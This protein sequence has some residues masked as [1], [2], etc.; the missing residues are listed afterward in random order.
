MMSLREYTRK[1]HFQ[2]TPEPVGKKVAKEGRS[3]VVQKH[4]AT[5][6]HYDFRLELEGVLKSWAVPK[7]PSLDPSVKR[8]A[9][10][11]EDHPVDYGNFEGTIP[12][13]EYGGGTVML[14]DRGYWEPVGDARE[15]Y[16]NGRLKFKLHGEKLRG[17]WMLIR[18]GG[19]KS[20]RAK[21]QWLLFKERDDEARP[22]DQGD[23]LEEQSLSVATG[24]SLEE[25]A[26]HSGQAGNGKAKSK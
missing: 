1:R 10:H 18:T 8:L 24:R 13:G 11:V 7:G 5:H 21:P 12:E 4:D 23:I 22:A 15:G 19:A 9:M 14:W 3:F 6:L 16:N 2:R 20:D 26:E 25:I 17:G